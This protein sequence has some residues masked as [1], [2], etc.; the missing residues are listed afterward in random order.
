MELIPVLSRFFACA[1][2]MALQLNGDQLELDVLLTE[3]LPS[4]AY[5]MAVAEYNSSPKFAEAASLD[6]E[7]IKDLCAQFRTAIETNKAG[8]ATDLE[9]QI[10]DLAS[11]A[12]IQVKLEQ[13]MP[14]ELVLYSGELVAFGDI[15]NAMLN[16]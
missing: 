10:W 7:L 15:I 4:V 13:F 6:P 16:S 2:E 3:T 8:A 14:Q 1:H 9:K 11:R 5:A 12:V